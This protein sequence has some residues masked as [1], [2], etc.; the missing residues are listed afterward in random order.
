MRLIDAINIALNGQAI[1]FAGSGFSHGAMNIC[2]RS[3]PVGDGLRDTIA[4]DCGATKNRP[5]ATVAQF[6]IAKKGQ[7][8]LIAL[9]KREFS[10]LETALWHQTLLSLPWKRVYTTNYDS[11]IEIAAQKNGLTLT[12]IVPS[13]RIESNPIDN[14]CVHFNGHINYLNRDTINNEFKL[15]D[16]SYSCD[17]LEGGEW[18]ELFKSDLQIANAIIVIGYSM[19]FDLD[20]KR[21]SHPQK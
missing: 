5:L 4:D 16:T 6:Y 12:T 3:F 14:V 20:I 19:Q 2:K 8:K 17:S 7:D 10:V 21:Y 1:L 13:M 9:L 15:I 11:V 18:F